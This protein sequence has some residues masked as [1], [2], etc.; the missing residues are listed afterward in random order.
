MLVLE[1]S[2]S[3]A[4]LVEVASRATSIELAA[5]D[6]RAEVVFKG[7]SLADFVLFEREDSDRAEYSARRALKCNAL[8]ASM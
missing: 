2:E 5:G 6:S 8:H 7:E 3:T 4:L 1:P